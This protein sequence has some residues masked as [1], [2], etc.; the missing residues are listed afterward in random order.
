M[1]NFI[2]SGSTATNTPILTPAQ[3]GS[4]NTTSTT[5]VKSKRELKNEYY[6]NK[7]LGK[8]ILLLDEINKDSGEIK[9]HKEANLN[10]PRPELLPD[11]IQAEVLET[12]P[13]I[14]P[15]KEV[16][17]AENP[18]LKKSIYN[19]L[20]EM[21]PEKYQQLKNDIQK[22]G[23]DKKFPI[24]LYK[25]DIIDGWNRQQVCYELNIIPNYETFK[26]TDLVGV[27]VRGT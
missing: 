2:I 12:E 6:L 5:P 14:V 24:W 18:I 21:Q 9:N 7:A 4:T 25:G 27:L 16:I 11:G 3:S 17:V 15:L 22:N 19:N 1:N 10:D 26:G 23:Y 20:P 13:R 8:E